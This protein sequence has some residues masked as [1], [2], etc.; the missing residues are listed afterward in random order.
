MSAAHRRRRWPWVVVAVLVA[1]FA[2]AWW[3]PARWAW[4]MMR[5]DYPTVHVG[6]IGGSVWNGHAE[7]VVAA[8]QRLGTLHWTLGRAAVFGDVHGHVDLRG[9]GVVAN[10]DIAHVAD[11]VV[12]IHNAHFQVP[13]ERLKV[14]WP[15]GLRLGGQLRGEVARMRLVHGW[16]TRLDARVRWH[17]ARIATQDRSVALGEL[18]SRWEASG[19]TVV[20][21]D[22]HDSG[23]GPLRL[24]GQFVATLLGWRLHAILT[25]REGHAGLR[26]L[27]RR[28][29]RP[30][31]DGSVR[32]ERRG[33]L[34]MGTAW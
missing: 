25:P 11:G 19:G 17:D 10:G 32:I 31:P 2:L 1:L 13:M 8:G 21:V 12:A 26:R 28:F 5:D 24:R 14:V 22:L 29:G 9:A 15:S 33:G 6:A 27:L 34:M 3:F 16:P 18:L 7:N 30:M 23:T 4:S 20:T